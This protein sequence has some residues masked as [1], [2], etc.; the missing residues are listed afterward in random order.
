M[1]THTWGGARPGSG[2]KPKLDDAVLLNVRMQ[3]AD[4]DRLRTV[5]RMKGLNLSTHVRRVLKRSL[6]AHSR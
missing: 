1:A 2:P 6:A 4:V 5:A 3:R